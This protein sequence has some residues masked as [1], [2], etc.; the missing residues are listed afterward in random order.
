MNFA[1]WKPKYSFVYHFI[2]V[3]AQHDSITFSPKI[4]LPRGVKWCILSLLHKEQL[5][6]N[7]KV[8][9]WVNLTSCQ[10]KT[11]CTFWSVNIPDLGGDVLNNMAFESFKEI[12]PVTC[13]SF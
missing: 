10:K 13:E 11:I 3:T 6:R 4:Y 12:F 5:F 2:V 7:V 9:V 1:L 8:K